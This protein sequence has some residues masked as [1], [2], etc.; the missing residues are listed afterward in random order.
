V[1]ELVGVGFFFRCGKASVIFVEGGV[2]L[3]YKLDETTDMATMFTVVL[4]GRT[5]LRSV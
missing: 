4:V 3:F 1:E 5:L 2:V